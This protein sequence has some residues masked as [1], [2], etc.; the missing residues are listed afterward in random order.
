MKLQT[1]GMICNFKVTK[2]KCLWIFS[3]AEK[4]NCEGIALFEI[5]DQSDGTSNNA[6]HAAAAIRSHP[7]SDHS[8]L[9]SFM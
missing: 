8:I 6:G 1:E 3:P 4:Y 5:Q 9:G 2:V 7:G